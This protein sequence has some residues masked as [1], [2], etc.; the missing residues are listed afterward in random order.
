MRIADKPRDLPVPPQI[1]TA[2][3]KPLSEMT[4]DELAAEMARR[5]KGYSMKVKVVVHEAEEGG[6]L[7]RGTLYTWL[8]Y[9]RRYIRR[10]HG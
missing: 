1:T 10:S 9:T 8:C 4:D 6:L 5:K 7:G 2:A 3:T